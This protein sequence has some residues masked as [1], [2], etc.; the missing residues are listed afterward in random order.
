METNWYEIE[1]H[2][3]SR[4]VVNYRG[5]CDAGVVERI[6]S[7]ELSK[8]WLRM[9]TV[10]W[11]EEHWDD[12]QQFHQIVVRKY[13]RDGAYKNFDGTLYVRIEDLVSIAP[14]KRADRDEDFNEDPGWGLS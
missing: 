1:T 12:Q 6:V 11:A 4:Q 3:G 5:Q 13:G 2:K 7:G 9:D 8:G 10:Y 14:L